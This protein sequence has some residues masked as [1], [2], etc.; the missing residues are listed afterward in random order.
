MIS[1]QDIERLKEANDVE[2]LI[3]ALEHSDELIRREAVSAFREAGDERAI[4]PLREIL[5]SRDSY[6]AKID[7]GY[8]IEEIVE[9]VGVAIKDRGKA[10][11]FLSDKLKD[12]SK[13]ARCGL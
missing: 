5:S 1:K 7:A 4:E 2:G 9:R 13:Y 3:K 6:T 12:N 10:I 11:E 8:A